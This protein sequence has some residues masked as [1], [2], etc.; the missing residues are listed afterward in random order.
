MKRSPIE[1]LY[2]GIPSSV[3]A[4]VCD[5]KEDCCLSLDPSQEFPSCGSFDCCQMYAV[6]CGSVESMI[7]SS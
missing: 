2:E 5:V 6:G 1:P 7:K 3:F 4:I